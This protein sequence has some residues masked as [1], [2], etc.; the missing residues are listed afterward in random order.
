MKIVAV[1]GSALPTPAH[2]VYQESVAVGRLLA[3][4]GYAVMTGG[5]NGVMTAASQGAYEA[6]GT[7]I[8]VTCLPFERQRGSKPNPY[9]TEVRPFETLREGL[10]HLVLTP[11]AFVVMPGGLGTLNEMVFAA[12][13]MRAGDIPRRSTVCYGSFWRPIIDITSQ[14]EYMHHEGWMHVRFADTPE[15][16]VDLISNHV[17]A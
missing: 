12:E 7:T 16:V 13:L 6:G 17:P 2:P 14:S 8:G 1:F 4:A 11:H 10:E 5:Y 3:Q 15:A 9:L